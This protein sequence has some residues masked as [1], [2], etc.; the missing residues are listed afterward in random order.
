[1]SWRPPPVDPCLRELPREF[2]G[3][4]AG[5]ADEGRIPVTL[6][7]STNVN[8][9]L[10][11]PEVVGAACAA[12]LGRYP[13]PDAVAARRSL[14]RFWAVPRA[15]IVLAPGAADL[16]Y[17]AARC[18]VRSGD[19]VVV[20]GPT[21]G[22]Y[23]RAV[24]LA[25][26][27]VVEVRGE[28]PRLAL[29]LREVLDEVRCLRPPLLFV[30][31]P[32]NPTG[33]ALAPETSAE[34]VE[35][36]PTGTLL[37]LDESYRSFSEGWLAP[38]HFPGSERVLHLRSFTKDLALPGLRI[39]AAVGEPLLLE[40]LVRAAPPWPLSSPA[41][42]ALEAA[43]RPGPLARLEESLAGVAR[44]RRVLGRELR[45]RQWRPLP[46]RTGFLLAE[47]D[48]AG[49]VC[50]ALDERGVR[51]RHAKSFGLPGHL[52]VSVPH[53]GDLAR[54]LDSVDSFAPFEG[55]A[56]LGAPD[57]AAGQRNLLRSRAS[58]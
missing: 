58:R 46:S 34:L 36:L 5:V 19:H 8:P 17:R 40:A 53:P 49:G 7:L 48:D 32:N 21:F 16:I 56:A 10:P 4:P 2:H 27:Y 24:R 50:R 37:V 35:G 42:T 31:S 38:P 52:R 15:R 23:G 6:D 3:G 26:G 51:L 55:A 29:P 28:P 57:R 18:F 12:E 30:C 45:K 9:F 47:V 54:F 39:A 22:E 44:L 13:D 33:E 1:M 43:L 41:Q 25:G 14:S 11:D 20:A